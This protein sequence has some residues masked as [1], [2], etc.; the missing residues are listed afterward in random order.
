MQATK[1]NRNSSKLAFALS[2][3]T[4]LTV[5]NGYLQARQSDEDAGA[6]IFLSTTATKRN[7]A[8]ARVRKSLKIGTNVRKNLLFCD[9]IWQLPPRP[10]QRSPRKIRALIDASLKS[11]ISQP[12]YSP[13]RDTRAHRCATFR[14]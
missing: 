3:M 13:K 9:Q 14:A 5:L 12:K 7:R 10:D 6:H 2:L 11:W 1:I 4:L 8:C